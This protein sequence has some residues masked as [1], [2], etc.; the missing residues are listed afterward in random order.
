MTNGND[1]LARLVSVIRSRR[2]GDPQTSY[3][4]RLLAAERAYTARK[5]GEEAIEL[6]TAALAEDRS[7]QV[8][9]AADV[10]FH[11]LVLLE[12]LDIGWEEV[13]AELAR[14]EGTSGIAEKQARQAEKF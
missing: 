9:E 1:I 11:M 8:A 5:F 13:L 3:V 7:A 6:V 4:A 10:V 2:G 14:R 12:S